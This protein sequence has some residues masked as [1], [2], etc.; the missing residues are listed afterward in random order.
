[1]ETAGGKD[2]FHESLTS[3]L[4]LMEMGLA[5]FVPPNRARVLVK[6]LNP[7]AIDEHSETG[8]ES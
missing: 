2:E 4:S 7:H 5:E 8:R 1:M 6:S 3:P